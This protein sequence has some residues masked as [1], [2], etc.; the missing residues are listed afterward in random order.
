MTILGSGR[1][2][3]RRRLDRKCML[4]A[5]AGIAVLACNV[6]LVLLRTDGLHMV[7]LSVNVITDVLLVWAAI[8]MV[9]LVILPER[10]LLSLYRRGER[11][12]RVSEGEVT[13]VA[14]NTVCIQGFPCYCVQI[15][16]GERVREFYLI[17]GSFSLRKGGKYSFGTVENIIYR[18][19][20]LP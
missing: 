11:S 14:E 8:A 12:G 7:F 16:Q 18:A 15:R 10:R 9:H 1:E 19:E 3:Y 6:L 4:L 17:E 13:E 20:V 2:E 5:A